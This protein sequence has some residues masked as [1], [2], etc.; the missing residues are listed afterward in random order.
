LRR[1]PVD[2]IGRVFSRFSIPCL[3]L[4]F[5]SK[6][7]SLRRAA[8]A[9][10]G[11]RT[12]AIDVRLCHGPLA[13]HPTAGAARPELPSGSGEPISRIADLSVLTVFFTRMHPIRTVVSKARLATKA[14]RPAR[15]EAHAGAVER[16]QRGSPAEPRL[17][18]WSTRWSQARRTA[19]G[20]VSGRSTATD[21]GSAVSAGAF[22]ED[23]GDGSAASEILA[24]L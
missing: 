6:K 22:G 8:G 2:R 17:K 7:A 24:Y 5:A 11:D 19:L 4:A 13:H 14:A 1:A 12:R 15:S 23:E 9:V 16:P 18:T 21:P 3:S 10:P 20:G